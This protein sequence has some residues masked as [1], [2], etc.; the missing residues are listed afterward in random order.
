MFKGLAVSSLAWNWETALDPGWSGGGL[1]CPDFLKTAISE[2][3]VPNFLKIAVS[4][5]LLQLVVY[6]FD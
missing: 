6:D 1:T 5:F 4:K 3:S 2:R